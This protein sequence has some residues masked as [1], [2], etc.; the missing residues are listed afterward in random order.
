MENEKTNAPKKQSPIVHVRF[1]EDEM[2]EMK[3][4][5]AE[6]G[7]KHISTLIQMGTKRLVREQLEL[8][9]KKR[10]KQTNTEKNF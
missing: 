5:I 8:S 4:V 7:I 9:K 1:T 3:A 6:M 10:G 2:A